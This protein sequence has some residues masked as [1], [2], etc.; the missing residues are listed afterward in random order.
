VTRPHCLVVAAGLRMTR[1]AK[2]V[3]ASAR[4]VICQ[5]YFL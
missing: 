5:L 3:S 4:P 1:K 2:L